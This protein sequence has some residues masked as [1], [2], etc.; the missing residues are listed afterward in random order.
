[1]THTQ[2]RAEFWLRRASGRLG[3]R[4]SA[5]VL[6]IAAGAVLLVA[7]LGTS[8]RA[9]G[10]PIVQLTI[11]RSRSAVRVGNS[12]TY[13]AFANLADGTTGVDVTGAVRWSSSVPGIVAL[14]DNLATGLASGQTD[15][16]ATDD[17]TGVQ[18]DP[19]AGSLR[20]VAQLASIEV[21]PPKRVLPVK[22][23]TRYRAIGTFEGGVE[24]DITAECDL[25]LS[26]PSVGTLDTTGRLRAVTP[27]TSAV[28]AEDRATGVTAAATGGN[29]EVEVVGKLAALAVTPSSLAVPVGGSTALKAKASFVGFC[30]Q[31]TYTRR[32]AWSSSDPA[33]ATVDREGRVSC[34]ADGVVSISVR[35]RGGSVNSTAGNADARIVCG[36]ELLAIRVSPERWTVAVGEKRELRALYVF[37]GGITVDGTRNVTWT[38]NAPAI[39]AI[40]SDGDAGSGQGLAPGEATVTASDAARSLSSN[41]A[42]GKNGTLTV[43]S[44][45]ASFALQPGAGGSLTGLVGSTVKFSANA[46]YNAGPSRT[47]NKLSAWSTSD[48]DVVG[49]DD[50]SPCYAAGTA[51]LLAEGTSTVSATYPSSAGA[52]TPLTAS[53]VVTVVTPAPPT[54]TPTPTPPGSAS[55]AF[56]DPPAGLLE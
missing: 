13:R 46:S 54:P 43:A 4:R 8:A 30:Q 27:G 52:F 56:L 35:D 16:T 45:L 14:T 51:R 31:Y 50:G 1:M 44:A 25:S 37:A 28:R 47:V 26:Q 34:L 40:G 53:V 11:T 5:G 38:T 6:A 19:A 24:L 29:A 9:Q 55:R 15:V 21:T 12:V 17:A 10:S 20:V 39:L 3:R 48:P 41:D 32:I 7:D 23:S 42:G 33:V 49:L 18:S 22:R 2:R 36:G